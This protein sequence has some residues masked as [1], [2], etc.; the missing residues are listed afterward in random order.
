MP[1]ARTGSAPISRSAVII[2][3]QGKSGTRSQIIASVRMLYTVTTK[4]I[5]A[6]MEEI[7]ARCSDK[8]AV[9]TAGLACAML[10]ERGG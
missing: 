9:S 10:P 4:L 5:D 6:A 2:I 3:D 8:I 1:A 7:P